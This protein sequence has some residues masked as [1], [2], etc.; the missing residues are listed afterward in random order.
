MQERFVYAALS[1]IASTRRRTG[2]TAS[3]ISASSGFLR[4]IVV[5]ADVVHRVVVRQAPGR[6]GSA[7]WF[8]DL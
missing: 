5:T 3:S 7:F 6:A 1:L 8:L 4:A 2:S